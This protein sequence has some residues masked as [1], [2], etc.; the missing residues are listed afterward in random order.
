MAILK[1]IF[2]ERAT[3][4]TYATVCAAVIVASRM[5]IMLA[6]GRINMLLLVLVPVIA[7]AGFIL[8]RPAR[9]FFA[10]LFLLP[11][12]Q[13][14]LVVLYYFSRSSFLVSVV[15][16]WKEILLVLGISLVMAHQAG[17]LHRIRM[18][19][20]DA[21]MLCYFGLNVIYLI[22]PW[23]TPFV[24]RLYGFRSLAILVMV[25]F[26]GRIIPLS[27]RRQKQVLVAFLLLAIVSGVAAVIDALILPENW[28]AQ[29]GLL[30]YLNRFSFGESGAQYTAPYGLPWT[31]W[32]STGQR[33]ASGFFA[34]PLDLAASIHLTGVASLVIALRAKPRTKM[35]ML[36]SLGFLCAFIALLLSIS[37]MSIAVFVL[38]CLLA[39]WLLHRFSITFSMVVL[40]A[41][42]FVAI[43]FTPIGE[44][45]VETVTLRNASLLGHL[46]EWQAGFIA[47]MQ[48]PLGMGPGVSGIVGAR[49][50]T[51][52]GG[53]NQ[54]IIIG[55]QLGILGLLLYILLQYF[56]VRDAIL[57]YNRSEGWTRSLALIVGVSRVGLALIA[58]TANTELYLF[59]A[60][61]SWWLV[62]WMHQVPLRRK[63]L[64]EQY[65]S[66]ESNLPIGAASTSQ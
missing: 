52:V 60:Y 66:K 55:V 32:T 57:L 19:P 1:S 63:Y 44:F 5:I 50:G 23:D 7:I 31:F 13:L 4:I 54:Y 62:G 47:M 59:S 26:L 21:L 15:Q 49:F 33:R 37:R 9:V 28:P 48:A 39:T 6:Q 3:L 11:A 38:E 20:M 12:Y 27:D 65:A 46:R 41:I 43:L 64:R 42:G 30:N 29:I 53:E 8:V 24:T 10:F 17:R 2:I 45:I 51:Q 25:Y 16:P 58:I 36:A 22:W 35:R 14:T 40:F 34:N 61:I 18:R 56:A